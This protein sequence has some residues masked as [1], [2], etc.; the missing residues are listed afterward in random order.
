MPILLLSYFDEK[1]AFHVAAISLVLLVFVA[2]LDHLTGYEF[3]FSIFY[4][5]PIVLVTWYLERWI[6]LVFCFL[7]AAVWLFVDFTSN[8]NYSNSLIP[9]WNT[10]VRLSFFLITSVL[11][12]ELKNRL[13]FEKKIAQIDGLS[14]LLN[15][16]AF[17]ELSSN[18]LELAVRHKHPV[19]LG[20]IDVDNFKQVNDRLG[21][22]EGDNVL[23][24]VAQTLARCVRSTDVA[25]R[26]GGDEFAIFLPETD[27][28]G[29]QIMFDRIHTELT[30]VASAGGWLIGFSIGVAVFTRAP[31]NIDEAIKQADELMYRVKK[32]G[33]NRLI[34]EAQAV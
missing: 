1:P 32:S 12:I 17:K 30:S 19:A 22:S 29:A 18:F 21:H 16:R 25:G 27:R 20:Y 34:Y 14:G 10:A 7:A 24:E 5:L 26:L 33:K 23:R 11:L 28:A 2:S 6:G 3:S 31:T 4:L 9:I 15:A 8:H 13:T